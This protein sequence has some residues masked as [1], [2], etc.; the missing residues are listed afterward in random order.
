MKGDSELTQR[1]RDMDGL[2]DQ[3]LKQIEILQKDNRMY[4]HVL[5]DIAV[6]APG[7]AASIM[8]KLAIYGRITGEEHAILDKHFDRKAYG[9]SFG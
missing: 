7:S 3:F 9:H 4:K 2:I 6:D 5:E 8:A 1:E